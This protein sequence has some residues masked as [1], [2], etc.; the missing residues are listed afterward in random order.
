[1]AL[2]QGGLK[3][4]DMAQLLDVNLATITRWTHDIGSPPRPIYLQKWAELC[5]VPYDW[6]VGDADLRRVPSR[7]RVT[8]GSSR[9]FLRS[10]RRAP[11]N[12]GLNCDPVAA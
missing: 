1:M 7:T 10:P 11:R 9:E 2:E 4:S 3:R 5:E 6:L 8:T 12:L